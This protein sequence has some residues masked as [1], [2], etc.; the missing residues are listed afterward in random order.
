[1]K[2]VEIMGELNLDYEAFFSRLGQVQVVHT[3]SSPPHTPT[4]KRR[5]AVIAFVLLRLLLHTLP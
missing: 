1:M 5:L 2:M 4:P 3:T